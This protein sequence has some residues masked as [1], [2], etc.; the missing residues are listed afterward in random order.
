MS[1]YVLCITESCFELSRL[2]KCAC[3]LLIVQLISFYF[4][5]YT[6]FIIKNVSSDKYVA[7]IYLL[8]YIYIYIMAP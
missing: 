1:I 6:M 8:I 2:H 7:F 3:V 4:I 5:F